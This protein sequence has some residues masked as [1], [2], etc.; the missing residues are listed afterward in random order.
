MTHSSVLFVACANFAGL[1]FIA[2]FCVCVIMATTFLEL[3]TTLKY[4]GAKWL[5]EKKRLFYAL[6][7]WPKVG[8]R[9]SGHM[10]HEKKKN[11]PKKKLN[12]PR[13]SD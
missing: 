5:P 10:S 13:D 4:L 1:F 8:Q 12:S 2:F 9:Y 11:K 7:C 6:P 3:A